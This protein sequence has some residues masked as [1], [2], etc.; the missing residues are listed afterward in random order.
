MS[1]TAPVFDEVLGAIFTKTDMP[2]MMRTSLLGQAPPVTSLGVFASCVSGADTLQATLLDPAGFGTLP[3]GQLLSVLGRVAAA[4]SLARNR[5]DELDASGNPNGPH[6]ENTTTSEKRLKII[7]G[8]QSR[9]GHSLPPD[10]LPSEREL[11]H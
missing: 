9:Y 10:V 11:S 1:A 4:W 8:L 5:F 7:S 2:E 3:E 6:A